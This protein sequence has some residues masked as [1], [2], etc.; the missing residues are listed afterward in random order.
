MPL[1]SKWCLFI[2]TSTYLYNRHV[3]TT[4]WV[5]LV[6]IVC[7]WFQAWPDDKLG[8]LSIREVNYWFLWVHWL[9]I[10][11]S[12]NVGTSKISDLRV[13]IRHPYFLMYDGYRFP[14]TPI[15][16][17]HNLTRDILVLWFL[18]SFHLLFNEVPCAVDAGICVSDESVGA[19][20]SIIHWTL[21]YGQLWFSVLVHIGYKDKLLWWR[22]RA[23]FIFL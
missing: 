11:L 12:L 17:R 18:E 5:C 22:V 16:R 6:W 4:C 21:H 9:P 23:T 7:I 10:V 1:V 14:S 8:G 13:L 3:N 2:I 20:L 15:S 19:G